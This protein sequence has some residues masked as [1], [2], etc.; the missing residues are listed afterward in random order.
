MGGERT[1][2]MSEVQDAVQVIMVTGRAAYMTGRITVKSLSS[3]IK[4]INTIYL[5]KWKG[6]ASLH[7]LR[8]T[9]GDDLVFINVS[10]EDRHD[11]SFVEK[12]MKAH[13]IL[14]SRMPDLC[15][16]DGRTQYAVA[17]T[18]LPKLKPML[19]DHAVGAGRNIMA[20]LIS[21][22]DYLGTGFGRDGLP[23]REY[24]RLGQS[25]AMEKEQAGRKTVLQEKMTGVSDPEKIHVSGNASLLKVYDL[26]VSGRNDGFLWIDEEPIKRGDGFSLYPMGDGLS[27]LL[28]PAGDELN[29][30]ASANSFGML[31]EDLQKSGAPSMTHRAV[32]FKDAAYRTIDLKTLKISDVAG[33]DVIRTIRKGSIYQR[34]EQLRELLIK[35][36]N[37]ISKEISRT[38]ALVRPGG[39]EKK[40]SI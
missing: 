11:L 31:Q 26:Q 13:G 7:R 20:G 23:T 4:L 6:S 33:E 27:A 30:S 21:E 37:E 3:F 34:N 22:Q 28:V 15:G 1:G 35:Y 14:F 40:W 9:K 8:Q 18:D 17:A 36:E 2:K 32:I 29:H 16:G 39:G 10:S 25:A 24:S 5:S 12:E 19:L 38:A